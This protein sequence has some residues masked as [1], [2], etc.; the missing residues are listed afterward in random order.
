MLSC[1]RLPLRDLIASLIRNDIEISFV[2]ASNALKNALFCIYPGQEKTKQDKNGT[3]YRRSSESDS[4]VLSEI[5]NLI[6]LRHLFSSTEVSKL[7]TF[8]KCLFSFQLFLFLYLFT[9]A[10]HFLRYH[11]I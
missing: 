2:F 1:Y 10:H 6:C 11:L 7:N 9:R 5:C 8:S 3:Y 4:H